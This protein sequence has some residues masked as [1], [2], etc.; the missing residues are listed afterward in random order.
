MSLPGFDASLRILALWAVRNKTDW[1]TAYRRISRWYSTTFHTP[2][3]L[4]ADLDEAFVLQHYYE[5]VFESL[6]ETDWRREAREAVETPAERE[7]RLAAE[8]IEDAEFL[9]KAAKG[10]RDYEAQRKKP[11]IGMGAA[12]LK[13]G[14]EDAAAKLQDA[15][16]DLPTHI[17]PATKRGEKIQALDKDA[18]NIPGFAA[19]AFVRLSELPSDEDDDRPMGMAP[20]P[21]VKR[22]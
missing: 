13:K 7:A 21:A 12:E 15:L 20:P 11:S 4:V 17:A 16:G 2:L 6:D 1:V 3:H 9:Q 5:H 14:F 18:V 22:R 10:R 8:L 19:D